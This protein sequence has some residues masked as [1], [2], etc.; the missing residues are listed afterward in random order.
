MPGVIR[1]D[2]DKL[3]RLPPY[4][5]AEVIDLMKTARREGEDIIDL[6]MGNPDLPTPPHVVEKI[7]EASRDPRNHRY[8]ASRGIPNLRA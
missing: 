5:L 2:F 6:G 7:C 8:S 1:H 3:N 4:I